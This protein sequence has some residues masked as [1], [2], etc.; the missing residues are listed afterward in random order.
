MSET[1]KIGAVMIVGAGIGGCQAALDLADSGLKV[2]LVDKNPSIGGVM[3]KLD[4]TFPTNDCSMCILAPKLVAVDRHP[5]IELITYSDV[6]DLEGKPGNFNAKIRKR[7]RYIYEDKCTGCGEC[8]QQCPVRVPDEFNENLDSRKAIYLQFPQAVPFKVQIDKKGI[9]PCRDACPAHVNAQG[10]IALISKKSYKESLDLIRERCPLPS[11]IGRICPRFCESV[12]NRAEIDDAINICGLKRFV[13]DHVRENLEDEPIFLEDKKEEKVAIVGSGPAGLT[14]A[15]H[16]A[17]RGYPVTIFE[18]EPFAGG[19]LRFGIPDYRLPPEILESDIE[20]IK[21]YGVEIKTNTPIGP[22][23]TLD[24]LK[25]QG[26][27]AIFIAIGLLDSRKMDF[28]CEDID[29]VI[30][31][32]D[33]LRELNLGGDVPNLKDK[34]V[35]IVGGGDVAMDAA[36]S[37]IRLGAKKVIIIYRR[38]EAEIPASREELNRAREEGIEF[39][40]LTVPTK[41]VSGKKAKLSEIECVQMKLGEPDESGRRR[42]IAIEGSEF[43]MRIDTLIISIGQESDCSLIKSASQKK[44]KINKWGYIET[45]KTNFATNIPGVFAGGEIVTGAGS[46]IEAIATGNKAAFVIEK[47]LKGEDIS[48]LQE[49]IP[50]YNVE[51]VISIEDI[52]DVDKISCQERGEFAICLPDERIY[53]FSEVTSTMDEESSI[54]EANRCLNCGSCCEC[55]ECVRACLAEAVDHNLTDEIISI[56]VGAVILAFG[57]NEYIPKEGNI[58]GYGEY[59]NVISSI[60][61]ERIL[62]ASGPFKGEVIRPSD[63]E[64]PKKV[65]FLQCVGSR[66]KTIDHEYCSSVCCMYTTKEAVIA[67]EHLKSVEPT[68]FSMDIRAFG[69]DF[70]KYIER[71]KKEYG[72][73][74]IRSRISGIK[75]IP[76]TN[77]LKIRYETEE[78]EIV[79]EVFNMVILSVGLQPNPTASELAKKMDVELNE[80]GFCK[81]DNFNPIETS[82][83]GIY[84]CGTFK[85]PKD[86]PETVVEASA[87]AGAVNVLLSDARNTLVAEEKHYEEIDVS[88]EPPRIGVFVCHCGINIGGVVNVPE[89]VEYASTLPDVV[90]TERNLYTCSADTQTIIK[91]KIK[92]KNINRVIVASCTPRTHEPLFQS[93]IREV[94]LNKYL[95]DLA[96]IRDQCSWVHIHEPKEATEKAKDLVRMSVA[97]AR[98]LVPLQEQKVEVVHK[99]MVIG[100]GVA[101]MTAALN[102]A[103]QGFPV[104]LVEKSNT[105]GGFANKIYQTLENNDVQQLVSN[106]TERVNN[107]KFI[108]VFLKANINSINGYLGNFR[109]ELAL[110]DENE[111][112]N[113]NHGIIILATGSEEYVPKEDDFLYGQDERIITQ[114][115]FED[116]LFTDENEIKKLKSITMI[117]CVGSRNEENPYCSR[118]CCAEAIKNAL[119]AKEINP[120]LNITILYRDI[121]T[122]GFKEKYYNLAREKGIL[123]IRFNE[124]KP[125]ELSKDDGQLQLSLNKTDIGEIKINTDLVVLSAGIV[126]PEGNPELAKFLKVPL[127]EDNFFLEAHVKLR[128][129]DFATEGIFLCGTARGPANITES[130]AQANSAAAR[131]MTILSKEILMTEGVTA[132]VN[133][134]KCIGCGQCAEICPYN[135]IELIES[136][137]QMGLYKNEI[138]K[139]QI[140]KALCKGCGTCFAECPVSAITM[141]HFGNAQIKPMITEAV[142]SSEEI[143]EPRIVAFLCNWCSYAGADLAGVSRFQYPPNLRIIRVMCSGGM[144]KSYILQAFL[145]GADGVFIAGCHLG[146]CHYISGNE[147][148]YLRME[149]LQK[150]LKMIGL[151]EERI[152]VRQISA[153]EGKQF[154]EDITEFTEKIKKLGES[155][156]NRKLSKVKIAKIETN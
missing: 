123:F 28:Q 37:S 129:S 146:D 52:Q 137:K 11:V 149:N 29:D 59:P 131:A 13:A 94:G 66:D 33:F 56:N 86:I 98:N 145:D 113:L 104:Y 150:L 72:V 148:A 46:A 69:K 147:N 103:D 107:H 115:S 105:L 106:L 41:D 119:K 83:P 93:T 118:M 26:Y 116:I 126:A 117:Q 139:A 127:N 61:F 4:K 43:K 48:E 6:L 10:Y 40:F 31:G 85:E 39:K 24:D 95:F 90:Y 42:P 144:S 20:H 153:S 27:K 58:Y 74:Y 1:N 22:D 73:R 80:Y 70:D 122:Y 135:A 15:Y 62:N 84:V 35:G 5:N 120:D 77:D 8:I 60:E 3:A 91:E 44:I 136:I 17:R 53:N 50:D 76:E 142:K 112:K 36:R 45:D 124:E 92:E 97:K 154:S 34:V 67:K 16:L 128:P 64:H 108:E 25:K 96:N 79:E 125:P 63:Q 47:F 109:T 88:G 55:F 138:K 54:Q 2:Y 78:G 14:V 21:K 99:G 12:C 130:I 32:V 133:E 155:K 121:R 89:V 23:L 75:E 68:I 134:E 30:Y 38:S 152:E 51:D 19:M 141:N 114:S 110:D 140:I 18:K 100:G 87:A 132:S 7:T 49:T 9:A 57:S 81:T 101:G 111:K 71:A 82:R 151:E 102:L 143:W 156:I 65:A